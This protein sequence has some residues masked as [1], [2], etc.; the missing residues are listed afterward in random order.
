M[1]AV[2]IDLPRSRDQL[3]TK[4]HP[5]FTEYRSHILELI[6]ATTRGSVGR[7]SQQKAPAA[8]NPR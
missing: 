5:R 6:R 2:V 1:E 8:V 3:E 7:G 4:S